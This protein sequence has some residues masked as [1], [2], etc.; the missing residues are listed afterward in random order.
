MNTQMIPELEC[1][2]HLLS[3]YQAGTPNRL[4]LSLKLGINIVK[5][6]T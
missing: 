2:Y 3:V 1:S 4:D 5:S 6:I